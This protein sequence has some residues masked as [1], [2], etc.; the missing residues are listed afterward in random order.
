M[1]LCYL[2]QMF[3]VSPEVHQ[4]HQN[5]IQITKPELCMVDETGSTRAGHVPTFFKSFCSVLERGPSAKLFRS[6]SS[7]SSFHY[8]SIPSH[9]VPFWVE[10]RS[11]HSVPFL[12]FLVE[13]RLHL[14]CSVLH[15]ERFHPPVL[16]LVTNNCIQDKSF[17]KK[18]WLKNKKNTIF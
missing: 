10:E 9:S 15:Q 3:Q 7:F 17:K 11:S 8:R 18:S 4:I 1:S 6:C 14:S 13:E 2:P 12:A 16:F 5:V